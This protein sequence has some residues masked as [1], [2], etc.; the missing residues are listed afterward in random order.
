MKLKLALIGLLLVLGASAPGPDTDGDW[1]VFGRD[2]GAQR[3]SP[4][5]QINAGNVPTLEQAWTFDTGVKDLQVTPLVIDGIMY[6]TGGATVFALE[7]ETGKVIWKYTSASGAVSRRGVAYWPGTG[8]VRARLFSGSGDGRMIA[9]DA[10]R[11]DL[12]TAFGEHGVVDL[13]TSVRGDVDGKFM[14]I[15]PPVVYKDIV[16]TGGANEEGEP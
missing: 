9:L 10:R 4:L 1:R 14:L 11:G 13:K 2:P 7:P 15:T 12:V 8:S 3:F 16:I 6:V 5:T